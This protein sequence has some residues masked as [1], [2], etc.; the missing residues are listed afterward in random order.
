VFASAATRAD[1]LQRYGA[2]F[3]AKSRL[4][5]H[6]LL[7]LAPGQPLRPYGEFRPPQALVFWSTVKPYKGV[8]LFLELARSPEWAARGLPLEVHGLWS[9]ELHPLRDELRALGVTIVDGFLDAAALEALLAR[10]VL[11]VLPHRQASQS[12]AL[13]TLLHHGCLCL[14]ADS[15][16]LGELLRQHGLQA[17]LLRERSAAAVLA[18]LDALRAHAG[19]L[20]HGLARAQQQLGWDAALAEAEAVYGS[21]TPLS[22]ATDA[23]VAM[24]AAG[25]SDA[26]RSKTAAP[27]PAAKSTR[28]MR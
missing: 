4:L 22:C 18:C 20:M 17:L 5:P 8:E 3:A 27:A 9:P 23:L 12:G 28:A 13:Y 26:A 1:F 21:D 11:F 25:A 19:A 15:G 7:P 16:D 10:D 14:C 24:D 2:G 6:G